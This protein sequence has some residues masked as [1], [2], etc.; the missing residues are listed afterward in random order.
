MLISASFKDG[1]GLCLNV[2]SSAILF[3]PGLPIVKRELELRIFV[4]PSELGAFSE[5]DSKTTA[6]L[7]GETKKTASR[8]GFDRSLKLELN[9]SDLTSEVTRP[10]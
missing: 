5:S 2:K 9:A 8:V 3:K 1:E 10:A 4:S 6:N 7:M